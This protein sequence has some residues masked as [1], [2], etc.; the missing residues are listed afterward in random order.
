MMN[1]KEPTVVNLTID[2]RLL[3]ILGIAIGLVLFAFSAV[4]AQSGGPVDVNDLTETAPVNLPAASDPPPT[5]VECSAGLLP[6]VNGECVPIE[7]IRRA[8]HL[9]R[10]RR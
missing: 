5:L 8:V 4:H 7:A 3:V 6:T 2:W 10:Q 1:E 9:P